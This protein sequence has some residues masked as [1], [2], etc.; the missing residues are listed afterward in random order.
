MSNKK[1]ADCTPEEW[2]AYLERQR[3]KR[4][5]Q[6]ARG[7]RPPSMQPEVL[8]RR[9]KEWVERHRDTD[10]Y[11]FQETQRLRRAR[12]K[13]P[14]GYRAK[15]R[16]W[17]RRNPDKV[18]AWQQRYRARKAQG[19]IAPARPAM[20]GERVWQL[21]LQALRGKYDEPNR[22]DIAGEAMLAFLEG[23]AKNIKDAVALGM[24]RHWKL[25]SKFATR[26]LDAEIAEGL[27]LIDLIAENAPRA[28]YAA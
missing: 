27:R 8:N 15:K 11:R 24:K 22:M 21:T 19:I 28:G 13:D 17:K 9:R 7:H 10:R 5:K 25:F 6:R 1:K 12:E 4:A 16:E 14:E 26:S 20:T 2:Q 3:A 23:D 18:R